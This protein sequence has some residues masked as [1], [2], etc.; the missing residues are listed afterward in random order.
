[1]A[2]YN[3]VTAVGS[4]NGATTLSA[5]STGLTTTITGTAPFT[6]TVPSPVLYAGTTQSFY[7]S[8][9]G[10]VTLST[11]SGVF[12]GA[13]GTGTSSLTLL[14]G[15]TVTVTS[16]GTN[17]I[18]SSSTGTSTTANS[19]TVSSTFT[20]TGGVIT[21]TSVGSV[22]A[23]NNVNIGASTAGTGAFL[24]LTA[25]GTVTLTS[26]SATH[27]ISSTAASTTLANNALYIAGGLGVANGIYNSGTQ[28]VGINTTGLGNPLYVFKNVSNV[29][30]GG[31]E[32]NSAAMFGK[33]DTTGDIGVFIGADQ[34]TNKIGWIGAVN[35]GT[36]YVPLVLNPA[37]GYVGI[38]TATS[39]VS[40]PLHVT[41]SAGNPAGFF[42]TTAGG[43]NVFFSCT[44]GTTPVNGYI[45]PNAWLNNTFSMGSST[46]NAVGI[47]VNGTTRAQWDTS[48]NLIPY[49]D[50]SYNLGSTSN[51]W[52]N[53][54]TADA[55][56]SN[57]GTEGNSVDG[58]TGNWTLQEGENNIYMLN[59][60][61]GKRYKIK[62]EEV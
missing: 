48:G 32:A 30:N 53:I 4:A 59:N 25:S 23:I 60:K 56:F 29:T 14:T 8:T 62:L 35:R 58:T 20:A 45:G 13:A 44:N 3:T 7:N 61:T 10:T 19:L 50:A 41:S 37:G 16:D 31:Q 34:G 51:R 6:V 21:L 28:T 1:M 46:N 49:S 11:P 33:S 55:H 57:E 52:N 9:L 5:P 15:G 27:S 18:V 42:S 40:Y 43:G 39:S 12:N 26:T 2:R 24:A 36:G 38:G 54:Y 47:V 17:Y 22:G